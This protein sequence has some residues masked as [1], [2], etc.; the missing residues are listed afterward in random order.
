MSEQDA[1]ARLGAQNWRS[2]NKKQV[3]TFMCDIAPSLSDEVRMKIIENTPNI[4]ATTNEIMKTYQESAHKALDQNHEI[5]KAILTCHHELQDSINALMLEQNATFEEKKYWCDM[6]F[7]CM[8]EMREYDNNNKNFV[9]KVLGGIAGVIG[10]VAGSVF[11]YS[12]LVSDTDD[13]DCNE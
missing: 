9:L 2:L 10:L 7:K 5:A 4:L 11:A 6:M 3:L 1:L 12:K 8:H 13:D